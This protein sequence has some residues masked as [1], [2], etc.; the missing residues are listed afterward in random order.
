MPAHTYYEAMHS[1]RCFSCTAHALGASPVISP[2]H[3]NACAP[4]CAR[5]LFCSSFRFFFFALCLFSFFVRSILPVPSFV[6]CT[7]QFWFFF[8]SN[9]MQLATRCLV[10]SFP[11]AA[12]HLCL[13]N[14]SKWIFSS[15]SP[16][17]GG[18][19]LVART[20]SLFLKESPP[21]LAACACALN[22][23]WCYLRARSR[24]AARSVFG[25]IVRFVQYLCDAMA[26]S[27]RMPKSGD[28][29]FHA[30][31]TGRFVRAGVGMNTTIGRS[32]SGA[33]CEYCDSHA[34]Y[35]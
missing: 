6:Q 10:H 3:E 29:P 13:G 2:V 23:L 28:R 20:R 26:S 8:F 16:V 17:Y 30:Q 34:P 14:A 35:R 12:N 33:E 18:T 32:F 31:H 22:M 5:S 27:E 4:L 15:S 24:T 19:R 11:F 9:W 7:R 1:C 25:T 21:L